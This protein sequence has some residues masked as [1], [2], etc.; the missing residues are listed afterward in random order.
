LK[1]LASVNALPG[2]SSA[3]PPEAVESVLILPMR[4]VALTV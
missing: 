4:L 1:Q 2:L 3:K